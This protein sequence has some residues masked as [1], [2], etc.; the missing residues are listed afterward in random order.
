MGSALDFTASDKNR[1]AY[2][3]DGFDED[4]VELGHR[5][6]VTFTNLDAGRYVL[7]L[8]G[9][10]HDGVWNEE[11]TSVTLAIAPPPWQS[12]WARALY[13]LALGA[14]VRGFVRRQQRKV[15]REAEY[16]E[17]QSQMVST[18]IRVLGFLVAFVMAIGAVF[19]ALNTMYSAVAAR[20][21]EIATMRALGFGGGSAMDAAK[22]IALLAGQHRPLWDFQDSGDNWTRADARAIGTMEVVLN[23]RAEQ[24]VYSYVNKEYCEELVEYHL[25][26]D[27]MRTRWA[28]V[29]LK[30]IQISEYSLL[31]L[32]Y[33]KVK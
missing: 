8:Q 17:R 28:E 27:E 9:A 4:W 15:E 7:R 30:V 19:G 22:S 31:Y 13:V 3:L 25:V 14:V 11:G 24:D 20:A 32:F 16:Y 21:R 33:Q 6:R 23:D 2:M 29:I 5:R 26:D 10:N 1:Y 12:W 18:L